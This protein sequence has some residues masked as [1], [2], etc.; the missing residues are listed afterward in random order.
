MWFQLYNILEKV[1]VET[2]K[3]LV[4]MGEQGTGRQ[5][6]EDFYVSEIILY[7]TTIVD[8]YYSPFIQTHR[9]DNV[10]SKP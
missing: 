7:D 10:K 2:V 3:R 1:T 6:K 4:V 5:N 8:A 9:I